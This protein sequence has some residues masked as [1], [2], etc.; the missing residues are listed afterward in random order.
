MQSGQ[1]PCQKPLTQVK[2]PEEPKGLN[3]YPRLQ[4]Y[5]RVFPSRN[6]V[7]VVL[8]FVLAHDRE[9]LQLPIG[10]QFGQPPSQTPALQVITEKLVANIGS[11]VYVRLVPSTV[12]VSE[13]EAFVHDRESLQ[14]E[15][16]LGQEPFQ[17]PLAS[18]V[19]TLDPAKPAPHV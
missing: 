13:V 17:L 4:L 18:H 7:S 8:A 9:L 19:R 11:H 1:L 14:L 15:V 2:R 12:P 3:V 6:P 16:Q 10:P 5:C